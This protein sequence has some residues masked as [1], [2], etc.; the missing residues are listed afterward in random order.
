MAAPNQ[1]PNPLE[2]ILGEMSN[3]K[4]PKTPKTQKIIIPATIA[5]VQDELKITRE[6]ITNEIKNLLSENLKGL[7]EEEMYDVKASVVRMAEALDDLLVP[8]QEFEEMSLGDDQARDNTDKGEESEGDENAEPPEKVRKEEKENQEKS[9]NYEQP[10]PGRGR[11]GGNYRAGY[12]GHYPQRGGHGGRGGHIG[13]GGPG[14][15]R[16]YSGAYSTKHA[17]RQFY[18]TRHFGNAGGPS[19]SKGM[20]C[21]CPQCTGRH[22]RFRPY[23]H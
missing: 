8:R 6:D 7:K 15:H 12:H 22:R 11:G 5:E 19:T 4:P 10:A 13:R 1:D 17:A 21:Y 9:K 2:N 20:P 14:H 23:G 18:A 3:K 16:G